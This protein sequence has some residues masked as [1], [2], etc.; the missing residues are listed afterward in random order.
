[1]MRTGSTRFGY[2]S[3]LFALI[4]LVAVMG[5]YAIPAQNAFAAPEDCNHVCGDGTCS[6]AAEVS[7]VPAVPGTPCDHDYGDNC[8][9]GEDEN[10]CVHDCADG[11]CAFVAEIPAIPAVPGSPCDHAHSGACGGLEAPVNSEG[12]GN[13]DSTVSASSEEGSGETVDLKLGL[14][15]LDIGSMGGSVNKFMC[16]SCY[17]QDTGSFYG[18]GTTGMII[19]WF[20]SKGDCDHLDV[21]CK[22]CEAV[23]IYYRGS[24]LGFTY[25]DNKFKG[26]I[27]NIKLGIPD[28]VQKKGGEPEKPVVPGGPEGPGGPG[29]PEPFTPEELTYTLEYYLDGVLFV[30]DSMNWPRKYT[31]DQ[32]D[33]YD[34]HLNVIKD[35]M[36]I[37]DFFGEGYDFDGF[38]GIDA[39]GNNIFS[40]ISLDIIGLL[41]EDGSVIRIYYVSS[42]EGPIE[43]PVSEYTSYTVHYFLLGT[44]TRLADDK[45]MGNQVLGGKVIENAKSI[46]GYNVVGA[47]TKIIEKLDKSG[48]VLVFYYA[49]APAPSLVVPGGSGGT[50]GG[51]GGI[52]GGTAATALTLAGPG[53]LPAP[54]V[55][56]P[57]QAVIADGPVPQASLT[58]LQSIA[59][60]RPPLAAA[61]L[62]SWALLN[63]ILTV[64]T[65]L[66]MVA[67]IGT[68]FNKRR[69][70]E[71]EANEYGEEKV[72]KYLGLRLISVVTAVIAFILFVFTQDMTLPIAFTDTWTIWHV[73]IT[74]AAVLLAVFSM[75]KYEEEDAEI[76]FRTV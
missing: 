54:G 60:E 33:E 65:A 62:A 75:K 58:P 50:G 29:E 73:V 56:I 67:L 44:T 42:E 6:F 3:K 64:A 43:D 68:Y 18:K 46:K 8:G 16:Y 59:V 69:R 1:M 45:N 19:A 17:Y 57:P 32:D 26:G 2:L 52:G 71:D 53:F 72:K 48:N 35:D 14:T 76:E 11:G 41:I 34:A 13:G 20:D 38:E 24:N 66:I 30:D 55:I 70:D 47:G 36:N 25:K 12:N 61:G 49:F 23:N 51:G 63:L 28:F 37:V 9:N 4:L 22:S 7:E 10:V 40:G 74:A 27:N 5:F 21:K 39:S 15:S 31:E